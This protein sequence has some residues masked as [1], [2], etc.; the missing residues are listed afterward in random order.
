MDW[1]TRLKKS[2]K[3]WQALFV[4][5]GIVVG[6]ITGVATSFFVTKTFAAE[7]YVAKT[8][9]EEH[10]SRFNEVKKIVEQTRDY[11]LIDCG[12]KCKKGPGQ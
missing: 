7:T 8:T 3:D 10:V 1:F 9:F 4:V 11:V 6:A 12:E 5:G 2:A